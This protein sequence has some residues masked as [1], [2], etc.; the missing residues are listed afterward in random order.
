MTVQVQLFASWADAL[1]PVVQLDLGDDATA[2]DVLDALAKRAGGVRLPRPAIAVNRQVVAA[3][4]RLS[5]GDEV[6]VI[7]PVAG[8]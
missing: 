2:G 5:P 7:P 3:A 6:A 4:R 1:G 8:G